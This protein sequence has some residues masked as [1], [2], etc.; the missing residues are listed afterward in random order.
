MMVENRV[1]QSERIVIYTCVAGNYDHALMPAAPTP[2]VDY[3][4]FTDSPRKL[5]APGWTVR[6]LASPPRL[7][8]GHDA[9]RF[10]KIFA[11]RLFPRHRWSIYIDGNIRYAGDLCVMVEAM[12][13]AKAGLAAFRHPN[14]HDLLTEVDVCGLSKFDA[15]DFIV[16][17]EQLAFY[18]AA[19]VDL[20]A[21]ILAACLL[22]RDHHD[23][24]LSDAMRIWWSQ[25]FEFCKRDQVSLPYVLAKGALNVLTLDDAGFRWSNVEQALH[26]L[27]PLPKRLL[28]RI[29]QELALLR[30]R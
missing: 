15:R 22:V 26:P 27:P 3:I 4:C 6:P 19:G 24:A 9:N 28:R 8:H 1:M 11:H 16:A 23:P 12:R 21:T 30:A 17:E 13:D 5:Q 10:H 14:G 18:E 2:L 20:E 7:T 25:L 29:R